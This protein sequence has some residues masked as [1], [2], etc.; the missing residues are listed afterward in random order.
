MAG[1]RETEIWVNGTWAELERVH[2]TVRALGAV[3]QAGQPRHLTGGD[4]GRYQQ[5]LRVAVKS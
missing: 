2:A 4:K 5:Y 3:V 1:I